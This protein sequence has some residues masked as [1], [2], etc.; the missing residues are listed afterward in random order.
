MLHPLK[1]YIAITVFF[2]FFLAQFGRVINFCLCSI[3]VYQQTHSFTCDCERQLFSSIKADKHSSEQTPQTVY[4]QFHA[5]ELHTGPS[6]PVLL[7][8]PPLNIS[9]WP[10]NSVSDLPHVIVDPV[11]HPPI[12]FSYPLTM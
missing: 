6:D 9:A 10:A 2:I 4:T 5:E 12:F 7:C 3:N 8:H 1:R 11:F